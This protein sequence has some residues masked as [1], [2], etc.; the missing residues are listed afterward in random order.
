LRLTVNPS[1]HLNRI[2]GDRN[3]GTQAEKDELALAIRWLDY[4][5]KGIDNGMQREPPITLF[6]MGANEWRHEYEWPLPGTQFT[7]YYFHAEEGARTGELSREIPGDE[8][9]T[10]YVY[11]PRDP[12]RTL[13][14]NHSFTDKSLD[15]IIRAG[16]VDQ[17]PNQN[18]PDVL[19]YTSAPLVED[20]EVT[21]P[22]TITLYAASSALDTDFIATLIDVESD[23]PA[24][25]LTQGI[26]RARFRDSIWD[27]P[28][29]LVPG[30][31]NEYSLE[32]L[33]TSNVFKKGHKIQVH[34]T[35]SSFPLWDRNPNTGH[36]QGL[37]EEMRPA[38]QTIY[39]DTTRPS[40]ILLPVIARG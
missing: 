15:H 23:G 1:D 20:T 19:V 5:V 33:P 40:H 10:S 31:V 2:P 35:S 38:Q 14:G 12:V 39:H 36:E 22:I 9:P 30:T 13:G 11:D 24:Y 7:R 21:G 32:L 27:P 18:R 26:I 17:S 28:R 3:F 4:V 29:L 25:N 6:V 16:S 37:D 8:R 34:L